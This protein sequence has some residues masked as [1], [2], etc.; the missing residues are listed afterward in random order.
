MEKSE[1]TGKVVGSLLL[2]VAIG[3][4]I[5]AALGILFAPEKGVD[6]RKRLAASGEEFTGTLKNKLSEF[7]EDVKGEAANAKDK[8]DQFADNR[9]T[10]V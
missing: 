8:V 6:M 7:I 10:T 5:G 3:G 9:G 1:N 4:A 2:G